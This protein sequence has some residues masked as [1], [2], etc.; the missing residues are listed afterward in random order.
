MSPVSYQLEKVPQSSGHAAGLI[1]APG[2]RTAAEILLKPRLG[3]EAHR[4]DYGPY[5]LVAGALYSTL[6]EV[7]HVGSGHNAALGLLKLSSVVATTQR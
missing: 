7:C 2:W 3:R 1:G 4:L 5:L 6:V